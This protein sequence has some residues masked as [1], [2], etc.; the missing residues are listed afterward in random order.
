MLSK[1]LSAPLADKEGSGEREA[2]HVDGDAGARA[3]SQ[4]HRRRGRQLRPRCE[5]R[6]RQGHAAS[7]S[8]WMD[9][10]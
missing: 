9:S 3:R 6:Q 7:L 5:Q 8:R 1:E 2:G 10:R 4:L